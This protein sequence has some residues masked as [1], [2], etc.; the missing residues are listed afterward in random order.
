MV[1][2][3]VQLTE[4]QLRA[5][6]AQAARERVSVSEL[7]RRAV[8]ARREA[9]TAPTASELKRR[10]LEA[11]GRFASGMCDVSRHHDEYLSDSY[12]S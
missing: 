9:A 11:A 12:R 2:V 7:V 4:E 10:A 1:R 8:G 5:L 3:Q 6:R